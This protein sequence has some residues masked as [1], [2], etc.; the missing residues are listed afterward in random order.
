MTQQTNTPIDYSSIQS[1]P[2]IWSQVASHYGEVIALDNPHSDPPVEIT[3]KE[4]NQQIQQFATGLQAQGIEP[5]TKVALFADNSPRW[6]IADQGTI[7]AGAAN[8][9]R[10]AQADAAELLYILDDSDS[11]AL[12]VE[13]NQTLEKLKADIKNPPIQLVILLSDETPELE[14]IKVLTYSQ[15]M[16]EGSK[17]EFTPVT[18]QD[19]DLATL[20]YT[21]GTTGKPKGA[22]L[23]HGNF[24]HQV[25]AIGDV[26]QPQPA[27]KALSILPSWHAYERAAEYFLLSRG[28]RLVYTN[29][30]SFKQDLKEQKPDYMVGVPRLWESIYDGIQKQLADQSPAKKK[31]IA[32]FLKI[33]HRYIKAK[34]IKEGLDLNNLHPSG[35]ERLLASIQAFFLQPLHNLADQIV[36]KTVRQATGGNLKSVISGGGSLAKHIDDFYEVIGIPLL[37]GYGLTETSP[38]THARRFDHNLRGSAGKAIPETETKIVDPETKQPLSEEEKG[39]VLIR[40]PQVMQGYYKKPEAT[41]KAI[42]EEG[43]FNTGDLGWITKH[44]DLVLTGRAKDTIVL[45]NGENIEPQP[46][47]DAC[48]RSPYIDQIMLV[49]QDQ[50]CLGALIVPNF[51]AL[52]AWS[53]ENSLELDFSDQWLEQTLD[54]SKVQ[55]LFREELNREVKNRPG[56]RPDDRIGVFKL[57]T[58]PFSAEN[59]MMTQTLKIKRPVVSERYQDIINGMF[60]KG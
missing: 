58:E 5:D 41:E 16:H 19:N 56:Y 35:G 12:I 38:V 1:L 34:R 17:H 32:V 10:S 60:V 44:D 8:V 28:C 59:G 47:E 37:V 14:G 18:R 23:S 33:S 40:G 26:I 54:N 6:F 36:Y 24:L 11:I 15:L 20:I 9:V 49:G 57:I 42:D 46:I 29:L 50:R 48:L 27:D 30:R 45:S 2:E 31:L 43:W 22:M 25:R 51:D 52:K 13:N 7:S 4:L 3:Y 21:S 39:L 55:K 53:Q